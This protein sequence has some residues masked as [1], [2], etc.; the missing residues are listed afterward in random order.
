M[1]RD[2]DLLIVI[3]P[4]DNFTHLLNNWG[5]IFISLSISTPA[6]VDVT[7]AFFPRGRKIFIAEFPVVIAPCLLLFNDKQQIK[8]GL[9]G[10]KENWAFS[11]ISL[12]RSKNKIK[13]K[14]KQREK[15]FG[16]IMQK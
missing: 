11:H 6:K 2:H 3:Y 14:Q 16:Q 12:L 15:G 5:Q 10:F 13:K 8:K 7:I 9:H 4:V 1:T